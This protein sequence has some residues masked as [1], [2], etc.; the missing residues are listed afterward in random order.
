MAV[1]PL[2]VTSRSVGS[3]PRL[4]PSILETYCTVPY[5]QVLELK[6]TPTSD[7]PVAEHVFLKRE[8]QFS[9]VCLAE[10]ASQIRLLIVYM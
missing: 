6:H 2:V 5:L 10:K 9:C 7:R 4:D 8:G 1:S 3:T